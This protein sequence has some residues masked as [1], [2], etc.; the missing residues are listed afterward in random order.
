MNRRTVVACTRRGH[1]LLLATPHDLSGPRA[2]P[3]NTCI[4]P[5][6]GRGRGRAGGGGCEFCVSVLTSHTARPPFYYLLL[7]R[8][9]V[10]RA[11]PSNSEP[12][13]PA[14]GSPAPL[15]Q[16]S[17][18]GVTTLNRL[19]VEGTERNLQTGT[20]QAESAQV[21]SPPGTVPMMAGPAYG[22]SRSVPG[23]PSFSPGVLISCHC[24]CSSIFSRS[25]TTCAL[26]EVQAPGSS[27]ITTCTLAEVKAPGFSLIASCFPLHCACIS[28]GSAPSGFANAGLSGAHL[29][30]KP[31]K[32]WPREWGIRA[33]G[34][35]L[36]IWTRSWLAG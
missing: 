16:A 6:R 4:A 29:G 24:V 8:N 10:D 9:A 2:P 14:P 7:H 36:G 32:Q 21:Q 12:G 27:L 13:R 11:A 30:R 22:V 1:T 28:S 20:A 35:T 3:P 15:R 34:E 18:R 33:W 26:A 17:G 25:I 5:G 31:L 23:F 19:N